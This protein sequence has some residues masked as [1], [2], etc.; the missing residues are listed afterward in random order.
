MC[1]CV[2]VTARAR[3]NISAVDVPGGALTRAPWRGRE[4]NTNGILDDAKQGTARRQVGGVFRGHVLDPDAGR[5][6]R[7]LLD[8]EL[9]IVADVQW[10]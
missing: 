7:D 8:G 1:V 5:G 2:C 10:S 3:P 4:G 9:L 6:Q